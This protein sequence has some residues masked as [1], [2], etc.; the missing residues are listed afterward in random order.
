ML[1]NGLSP[2]YVYESDAPPEQILADMQAVRELDDASERGK[3]RFTKIGCT[4]GGLLFLS[5][6]ALVA[7]PDFPA[8]ALV[9]IAAITLIVIGV[10]GHKRQSRTDFE[11][12]RF[13]LLEELLGLLSADM[14]Q[15]ASV[16]V[17]MDLASPETDEK[18]TDK[19]E[20][21]GWKVQYY[22]DPWLR[23][24][25]ALLD[26]TRFTL[27]QTELHQRRSRWKTNARGKR[28]HK[29][30]RR[31]ALEAN[32]VL[33]YKP[34]KHTEI[35]ALAE[36]ASGAVQ[37]PPGV[38]VKKLSIGE[39]AALLRVRRKGDW[40]G[41]AATAEESASSAV[42]VH[43]MGLLSLYRVLNLSRT[44]SKKARDAS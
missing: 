20:L 22:E 36:N 3:S 43:A 17:R 2:N 10:L 13:E 38:V 44:L 7:I 32:V 23:I 37:M 25:G 9:P 21:N 35:Q 4:G 24:S 33:R 29:T 27:E 40:V 1:P 26:G 16:Q 28:K 11:D 31:G 15:G 41:Q 14:P 12:R 42:H 39:K 34:R 6:P 18:Q 30:K 19:G 5:F 8:V